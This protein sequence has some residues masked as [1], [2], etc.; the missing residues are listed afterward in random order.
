MQLVPKAVGPGVFQ[1]QM[2]DM[3]RGA[4]PEPAATQA[5]ENPVHDIK[6]SR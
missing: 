3:R 6:L 5:T 4:L 1:T 2:K